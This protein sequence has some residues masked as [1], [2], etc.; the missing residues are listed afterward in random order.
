[1]SR[2]PVYVVGVGMTKFN[3]PGKRTDVDYTDYALEA[4]AKALL[5][6][7]ITYDLVEYAAVGYVFGESASGQRALY[8]LGTFNLI[9]LKVWLKFQ[10]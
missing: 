1:M 8:Q 4:A 3:K 2:P 9:N 7:N 10:L 5:D 6:A